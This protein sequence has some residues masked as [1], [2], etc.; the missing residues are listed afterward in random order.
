M[1]ALKITY[2][3]PSHLKASPGNARTH[4]RK[5]ILQIARSI[6]LFGFNNPVLVDREGMIV[7]GHGRVAAALELGMASVPTVLLEHLSP[8]QKRA[9]IIADNKLAEQAG[10]DK[11]I[12]QIELQGL[13]AGGLDFDL[14]DLGFET[15][16]I[17]LLLADDP[18]DLD[19]EEAGEERP[20]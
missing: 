7:A 15:G 19:A 17:D 14:T 11:A 5:Q 4:S 6:S 1:T 12:L 9:Y 10:W 18:N 3:D 16:E 20:A 13:T 2:R 8:A